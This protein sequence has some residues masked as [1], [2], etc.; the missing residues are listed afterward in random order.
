MSLLA[1]CLHVVGTGAT[2]GTRMQQYALSV[3]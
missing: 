2:N 1:S 3:Q